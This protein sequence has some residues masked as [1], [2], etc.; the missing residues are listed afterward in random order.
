[1][2]CLK[3]PVPPI[4]TLPAGLSFG[5]PPIPLIPVLTLPCCNIPVPPFPIVFPA[6]TLNLP[7]PPAVIA[8]LMGYLQ[9]V[10]AFLDQFEISCPLD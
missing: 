6:L 8:T 1:M 3:L 5:T 10:Q 7:F 2:P 4:P 9:A